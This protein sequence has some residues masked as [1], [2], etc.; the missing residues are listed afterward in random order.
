[1]PLR[2]EKNEGGQREKGRREEEEEGERLEMPRP[3]S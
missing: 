3:N 2:K 1:M